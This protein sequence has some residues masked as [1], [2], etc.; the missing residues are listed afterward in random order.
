VG[1]ASLGA[2]EVHTTL[3]RDEPPF[4]LVVTGRF[5]SFEDL[6]DAW[7]ELGCDAGDMTLQRR[8]AESRLVL[9]LPGSDGTCAKDPEGTSAGVAAGFLADADHLGISLMDAQFTEVQGFTPRGSRRAT[10]DGDDEAPEPGPDGRVSYVLAWQAVRS[11][12]PCT[13]VVLCALALLGSPG[14]RSGPDLDGEP[15]A[16]DELIEV[17]SHGE[18]IDIDD[19]LE[20]GRVTVVEYGATWCPACRSLE[21]Q[22]AALIKR[23]G[24]VAL[25]RVDI[26]AWDSPVANDYGIHSIPRLELYDGVDLVEDDTQRVLSIL[27]GG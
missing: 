5:G 19:Y 2:R 15:L 14:C 23:K 11:T 6:V 10:L 27:Q 1:L 3:L 13:V 26:R 4:A 25:K 20:E 21:P 18:S 7:Q 16:A 8:G 17:I 24:T 12:T 22:L 9:T